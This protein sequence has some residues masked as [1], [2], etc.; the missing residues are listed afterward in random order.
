MLRHLLCHAVNRLLKADTA[1]HT[2][3]HHVE[4]IREGEIDFLLP[5][6]DRVLDQHIRK[7]VTNYRRTEKN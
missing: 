4:R 5:L 1:L 2:D 7:L 3:Q 6:E